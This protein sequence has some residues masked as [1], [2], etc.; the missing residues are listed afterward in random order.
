MARKWKAVVIMALVAMMVP[1]VLAPLTAYAAEEKPEAAATGVKAPDSTTKAAIAIAVAIVVGMSC[2]A[3]GIAV[4]RV[5]SAALGAASERPELLG[6]SLILVG[7]AEGI[8]IYGL[9]VGIMLLGK[10]S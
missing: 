5:G 2:Y 1:A 6:R 7:L 9:I 8:A 3:A 10:W 4:G